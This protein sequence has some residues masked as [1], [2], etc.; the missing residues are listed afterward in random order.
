MVSIRVLGAS[1]RYDIITPIH[2]EYPMPLLRSLDPAFPIGRQIAIEAGPVVL[3]NVF[4]M[5]AADEDASC[6]SGATTPRG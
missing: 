4:T 1:C 3:V 6:R 2:S 5:D